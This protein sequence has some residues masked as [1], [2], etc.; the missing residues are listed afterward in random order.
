MNENSKTR[1]SSEAAPTR[2]QFLAGAAPA[3]AAAAALG[4]AEGFAQSAPAIPSVR[5]PKEIPAALGEAPVVG[6]FEGKG[7][8]G[9][10][11]FAQL[12]KKEGLAAM[13]CCP[14]NYT[15]THAIAAAGVPSY[16]G[17]TETN[18][19]A[20]ADGFGRA[21]G[22]VV[23][24]SGT[25]G[26]G[27]TNMITSIAAAHFAR[28][29]L[30]VLASNVQLA[31]EDRESGIQA[32]YQ[33]PITEGIKK[34]GKRMILPNRVH[35]YGAYA[36][37]QLKTGVPGPVHLDFPGEIARVR[38][39]DAGT[40][41]DYYESSRY[42]TECRSVPAA[43]DIARAV[44]II[45]KAERPLVVAGH[46]VF[47]RKA[48]NALLAVVEKNELAVVTS[49]PMRGHFPDDHRLAASLS[50][51]AMMSADLL[52]FVG[53]Y[54]MP[55]PGEY[56]VNP[57]V[58]AIRVHPEA[59]D[60]GRNWPLELGVV[61]DEL[62]FLEALENSLPRRTRD[63]WVAEVAAARQTYEQE[64]ARNYQNGLKYSADTGALHPSVI[65]KELNDFLYKGKIDPR[66][67]LTGWGGF[68]WQRTTV[69]M[70]R[71]NRPGQEIVCPYQFGAIG[72]DMAM[73]IGA[74]LAAKEGVGPQQPYQGAP[75][76][77]LTTDAGMGFTLLEL[78]TAVKYKV[79]LITLVYNND[80]WGT[81]TFAVGSPRSVHLHLF[82]E[83]LRYDRMAEALGAHGAYVRTPEELRTAL[84]RSYDVAAR[85]GLPSLINVQ[86]KKEFSSARDYPPG[87]GM[88]FEPGITGFQH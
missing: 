47:H 3:V 62:A 20:A 69:P 56:R 64:L 26:P 51:R 58:K 49:G 44:E 46:G 28:I 84:A 14:G 73:M 83:G 50:P 81:W 19:A 4:P 30:L 65:G 32:M 43:K 54:S 76:V 6:T 17:R 48:W 82:Q 7:M 13:F 21:T 36:F 1:K 77:C 5:I 75:S 66:Q 72:P 70:L 38:F 12:C 60:L 23:A 24:C 80:C 2:R 15:V 52:I 31:G 59:G 41:T 53:Q 61:G 10:E 29:P 74:A 86:A 35:E 25:E 87:G 34:Y 11:V 42:R 88:G 79:P 37:R 57:D 22:E 18:M 63:A 40:L 85:E 78:D 68:S 45:S 71:A 9:A 39:T 8:T 55:S 67:T 33:Q 27:F 16:G